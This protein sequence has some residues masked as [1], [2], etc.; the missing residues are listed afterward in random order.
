GVGGCLVRHRELRSSFWNRTRGGACRQQRKVRAALSPRAKALER[1][2]PESGRR[3]SGTSRCLVGRSQAPGETFFRLNDV[4]R[5]TAL[6]VFSRRYT[7]P[8]TRR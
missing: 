4:R 2:G 8:S 7:P 6:I 1:A 5:K 3:R